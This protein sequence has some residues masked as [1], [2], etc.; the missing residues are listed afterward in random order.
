MASPSAPGR[1]I[2]HLSHRFDKD[3]LP[4]ADRHYNRQKVGS[5][6]FVPPGTCLVLL[7]EQFDALWVTNWPRYAQHEWVGAWVNTLFR[8]ESPYFASDLIVQAVAATRYQMGD[9]P[10]KGM[11][12]FVDA[13]KVEKKRQPGRVYLKAGFRHVGYTQ[14]G[15]WV[16]QLDPG[17]MP[18]PLAPLPGR[19]VLKSAPRAR[20]ARVAQEAPAQVGRP[21]PASAPHRRADQAALLLPPD[22]PAEVLLAAPGESPVGLLDPDW[23]QLRLFADLAPAPRRTSRR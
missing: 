12:T 15:L 21:Q 11:I 9:P 3:A 14:K 22:G 4:L 18:P 5:P 1:G 19:F 17:D 13:S 7:A 16:F 2:W 23:A 8:N 6:Q 20:R 10:A